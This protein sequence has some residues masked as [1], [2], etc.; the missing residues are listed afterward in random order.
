[1]TAS[2]RIRWSGTLNTGADPIGWRPHTAKNLMKKTIQILSLALAT[3]WLTS[4]NTSAYG[5]DTIVY[6]SGPSF[7]FQYGVD[8]GDAA[9]DLNGDGTPDFS[10]QLSYF[11][12]S[13]GS[14]IGF[15]GGPISGG[16]AYGPYLV[17]GLGMNS[18]L[19]QRFSN[20]TIL[21]FGTFIGSP[22][23][24]NSLWNSPD[25]STAIATLWI[26]PTQRGLSGPLANVGVGYIG[27]RFY[28]ADGW[29]YGWIRV[30]ST[31]VVEVVDWA[32]ESR[33]DAPI[34]A[35]LIGSSRDSRQFTVAFPNGDCG[36]LILTGD[37]LRCELD[38]DGQFDSAKLT[39]PAP[40]RARAKSIADLGQPLVVTPDYTSFLSDTTL[41]RGEVMQLLRGNVK[42]SLDNGAMVGLI[43]PIQW[44]PAPQRG[45]N[46]EDKRA[47]Y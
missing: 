27:V 32:Y 4:A 13:Y 21:P 45:R 40:I 19:F 9:I 46:R 16:G 11:F 24:T 44:N 34:V 22:S 15:D 26:G 31:P 36:S 18:T 7:P 47:R 28:A 2:T 39:G 41:N 42:V 8:P 23:P 12:T 37:Q 29:H 38:L 17:W 14:F 5:R 43:E 6:V 10:F 1:M 3:V 35:G 30:R 33:P 25:Q 20:G